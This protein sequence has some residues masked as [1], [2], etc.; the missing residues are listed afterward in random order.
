MM[1]VPIFSAKNYSNHTL[2]VFPCSETITFRPSMP[3]MGFPRSFFKWFF[4]LDFLGS[5]SKN[6]KTCALRV[7]CQVVA[8]Y[9]SPATRHPPL[10][11]ITPSPHHLSLSVTYVNGV[12]LGRMSSFRH[13]IFLWL[14]DGNACASLFTPAFLRCEYE[15]L[16][17]VESVGSSV[18]PSVR[19]FVRP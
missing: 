16:K 6:S 8:C 5:Q 13:A 18:G 7:S 19:R 9:S 15:S 14:F 2:C 17:E 1:A 11:T 12:T 4:Y 3:T 10:V